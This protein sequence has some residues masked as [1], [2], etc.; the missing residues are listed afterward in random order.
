MLLKHKRTCLLMKCRTPQVPSKVEAFF[1]EFTEITK[2]IQYGV[3]CGKCEDGFKLKLI[4][5]LKKTRKISPTVVL[6]ERVVFSENATGNLHKEASE[7]SL[8]RKPFLSR[9]SAKWGNKLI[10]FLYSNQNVVKIP[11]SVCE[12]S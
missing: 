9:V 1:P 2:A 8:K 11:E 3:V 7:L 4:A 12:Y 5:V 10:K 6:K